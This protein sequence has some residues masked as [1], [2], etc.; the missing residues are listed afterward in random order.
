M[1]KL[2]LVLVGSL[3]DII[4][5]CIIEKLVLASCEFVC[6]LVFNFLR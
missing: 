4:W 6:L 1:I 3:I 5:R 2:T